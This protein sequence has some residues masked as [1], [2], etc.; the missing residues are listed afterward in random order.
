MKQNMT[1]I[2]PYL[3]PSQTFCGRRYLSIGAREK[4]IAFDGPSLVQ[5]HPGS[6]ILLY[7]GAARLLELSKPNTL[8]YLILRRNTE[9][10]SRRS[11]F[12]RVHLTA[13]P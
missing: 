11:R 2:T 5:F 6:L 1:N 13:Q 8:A 9:L 10:G 7:A 4:A 3:L 12:P